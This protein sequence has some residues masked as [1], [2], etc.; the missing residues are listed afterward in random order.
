M[1]TLIK[2]C[3][4]ISSFMSRGATFCRGAARQG[5][6]AWI[7]QVAR[8]VGVSSKSLLGA[9]I[10]FCLLTCLVGCGGSSCGSHLSAPQTGLGSLTVA[11]SGISNG[12]SIPCSGL[13][14]GNTCNFTSAF[15]V[16]QLSEPVTAQLAVEI[17]EDAD[18]GSFA[19]ANPG[20][21]PVFIQP[22]QVPLA[23]GDT[24]GSLRG[25]LGPPVSNRV[26]FA[27]QVQLVDSSGHR[28]AASDRVVNLAPE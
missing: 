15:A 24:S 28:I 27:L 17:C 10:G 7:P 2:E 19:S 12:A 9:L 8:A 3:Y 14:S 22:D 25:T 16:L 23:P 4:A 6:L 26:R 11:L 20:Q 1:E 13:S 18:G 5:P 21:S